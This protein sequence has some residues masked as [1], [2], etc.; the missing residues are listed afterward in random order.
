MKVIQSGAWKDGTPKG[1]IQGGVWKTPVKISVLKDGVWTKAWPADVAAPDYL[2][3]I[4]IEYLTNYQVKFTALKG[5]PANDEEAFMFRC[6]QMPKD[7]YT[8]RV[9]TK[10]WAANGYTG[11]DCTLEDLYGDGIP[12]NADM[13][14]KLSFRITPRP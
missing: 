2:Y 11:L 14:K 7:G 13:K 1:V 10:Q 5:L 4:Q 12:A 6:V 9:F 3:D 8:G